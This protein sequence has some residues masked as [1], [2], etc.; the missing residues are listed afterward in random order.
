MR[1]W[2]NRTRAGARA[3][4][5]A[6]ETARTAVLEQRRLSTQSESSASVRGARRVEANHAWAAY[7]GSGLEPSAGGQAPL[8]S[9]PCSRT[10][11]NP[12]YGMLGESVETSASFEARS[13][14]PSYPTALVKGVSDGP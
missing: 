12:T 11:E 13:A 14:P 7:A 5:V 10:G 4:G 6:Q 1:A 3:P 2:D 9:R 8:E